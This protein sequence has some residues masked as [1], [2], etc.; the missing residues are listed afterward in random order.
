[1][2]S[3]NFTKTQKII[4]ISINIY[5][6]TYN[7]LNKSWNRLLSDY[8]E[9]YPPALPILNK[10][11]GQLPEYLSMRKD[12]LQ[13]HPFISELARYEWLEIDIYERKRIKGLENQ[14]TRRKSKILSLNPVHE[15]CAF[16]YAIPDIVEMIENNQPLGKIY[17]QRT[18]VLIYRDPKD[19]SVRFFE[20]STS[21]LAFIEL[22]KSGFSIDMVIYFLANAYKIDEKNYKSFE[23][24]AM[25]LIK[26]LKKSRILI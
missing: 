17:K 26:T 13:K 21:S 8:L 3:A 23:K 11:V 12:I 16:Q 20:L 10:T 6:L 4:D 18:I 25:K 1:M 7:L 2:P 19:F 22:L 14:R 15:I 9:K 5:P 24:E